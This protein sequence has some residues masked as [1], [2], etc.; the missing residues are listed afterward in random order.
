MLNGYPPEYA[1]FIY[2]NISGH[3]PLSYYARPVDYIEEIT[4]LDF[5]YQLNDE[6]ENLIEKQY[7][8][9]YWE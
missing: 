6:I 3:N 7:D 4:K 5:F 9:T 1:G 2:D 8:L